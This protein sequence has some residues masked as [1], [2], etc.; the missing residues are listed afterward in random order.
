[1]KYESNNHL[2]HTARRDKII[3]N[4]IKNTGL[5][6]TPAVVSEAITNMFRA[7]TTVFVAARERNAAA[8]PGQQEEDL[9]DMLSTLQT[10]LPWVQQQQVSEAVFFEFFT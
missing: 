9:W 3:A 7:A 8:A 6:L 2:M 5:E 4:F 10:Q 1:V